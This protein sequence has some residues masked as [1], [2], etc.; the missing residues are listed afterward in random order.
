MHTGM[1]RSK[2]ADKYWEVTGGGKQTKVGSGMQ[3]LRK[4][5]WKGRQESKWGVAD[6]Q[7][8]MQAVKEGQVKAVAHGGSCVKFRKQR[9]EVIRRKTGCMYR[10]CIFSCC[11]VYI[12]GQLAAN[13]HQELPMLEV[14]VTSSP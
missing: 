3:R 1:Q 14:Q 10:N 2:Q 5:G 12:S 9:Q 7:E 13:H 8:C 4:Q 11:C 6:R